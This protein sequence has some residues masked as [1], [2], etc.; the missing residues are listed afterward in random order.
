[1]KWISLIVIAVSVLGVQ[2]VLLKA[3]DTHKPPI[4][5]YAFSVFPLVCMSRV[6]CFPS[7]YAMLVNPVECSHPENLLGID[8]SITCFTPITAAFH[9]GCTVLNLKN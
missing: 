1:M 8:F 2:A 4:L 9:F 3:S 6:L 5:L 7:L